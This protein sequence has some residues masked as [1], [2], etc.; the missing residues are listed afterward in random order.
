MT[1]TES[2]SGDWTTVPPLDCRQ[3]GLHLAPLRLVGVL[4][5]FGTDPFR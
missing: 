2:V 4:L 1:T 3:Q 5:I